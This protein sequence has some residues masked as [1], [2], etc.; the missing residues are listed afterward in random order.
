MC[1]HLLQERHLLLLPWLINN[2]I[3]LAFAVVAHIGLW[4]SV[5]AAKPPFMQALPVILLSVALFGELQMSHH[6]SLPCANIHSVHLVMGYIHI[7]R[8]RC[9][10]I[11]KLLCVGIHTALIARQLI[12]FCFSYYLQFSD[13]ICTMESTRFS[14]KFRH[15]ASF[16]AH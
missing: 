1:S 3:L 7:A 5:I 9:L 2:G 11:V 10:F 14:S 13:G 16:S 8:C 12:F 6:C 15:P 4:V